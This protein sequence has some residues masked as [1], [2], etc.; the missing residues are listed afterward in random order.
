[1]TPSLADK[2]Q[3]RQKRI[4]KRFIRAVRKWMIKLN[5][6]TQQFIIQSIIFPRPGK[7]LI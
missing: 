2:S 3:G 5:I 7:D 1:M 4:I 6:G